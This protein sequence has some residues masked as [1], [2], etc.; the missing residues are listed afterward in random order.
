M[1]LTV[2]G[3]LESD[4]PPLLQAYKLIAMMKYEYGLELSLPSGKYDTVC[5]IWCKGVDGKVIACNDDFCDIFPAPLEA[6]LG[7][8][9]YD[10]IQDKDI[11][12]IR[13]KNDQVVFTGKKPQMF[14]E[15]SM[16]GHYE[17]LTLPVLLSSA[18]IEGLLHLAIRRA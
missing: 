1:L 11:K 10:L 7:R 15:K 5:P 2:A 14:D 16:Y 9:I 3:I 13:Q 17:V 6:I 18:E 8:T 12:D 4:F